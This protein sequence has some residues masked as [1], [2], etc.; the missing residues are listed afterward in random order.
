M[1]YQNIIKELN[2]LENPI[3]S[4]GLSRF[5]KTGPGQYGEGDRFLG[6]TVPVTRSIVK[7]YIMAVTLIDIEGLLNSPIH[8]IRLAGVIFLV[9]LFEKARPQEQETIFHFYLDHTDRINNWDLVD[10]SAP[11]IV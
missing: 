8:E 1:V 4:G 3:K 2:A 7:K 5:F 9:K 6:I 10:V 11:N